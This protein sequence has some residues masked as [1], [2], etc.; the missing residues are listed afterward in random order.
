MSITNRVVDLRRV[1]RVL[2]PNNPRV[3]YVGYNEKDHSVPNQTTIHPTLNFGIILSGDNGV[4]SVYLN[5][6]LFE[7]TYPVAF[8]ELPGTS[9][10]SPRQSVHET[11]Y[12]S[13]LATD[14]RFVQNVTATDS[15]GF[16]SITPHPRLLNLT[17]TIRSLIMDPYKRGNA[18]S[19]D[20]HCLAASSEILLS[21]R[22]P[23]PEASD[24]EKA[25]RDIHHAVETKFNTSLS[26]ERLARGHGMSVRTLHRHW[27]KYY[28]EPIRQ[29]ITKRRVS[30]AQSLL[31]QDPGN[32]AQVARQVGYDDPLYFSRKFREITGTSPSEFIKK[33]QS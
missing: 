13:Y 29:F 22:S 14:R 17:R 21:R 24:V 1:E 9:T 18:D 11:F 20:S 6:K 5:E 16:W 31:V 10:R 3:S 2:E 7:T 33:R 28:S 8:V 12:F 26:V 27:A 19:L 23:S 15:S 30:E 32:I 4:Y 25:I